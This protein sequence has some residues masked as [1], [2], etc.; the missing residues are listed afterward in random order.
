V[1]ERRLVVGLVGHLE[2]QVEAADQVPAEFLAGSFGGLREQ[3]GTD[4][5]IP[6]RSHPLGERS[7]GDLAVHGVGE[8]RVEGA[9]EAEDQPDGTWRHLPGHRQPVSVRR[10]EVVEQ[11]AERVRHHRVAGDRDRHR[12]AGRGDHLAQHREL[13]VGIEE[14]GHHLEHAGARCADAL[15]DADQFVGCGGERRGVGAGG[16]LVVAGAAGAESESPG[17]DALSGEL[18]HRRDV[19]GGGVFVVRP[20]FTHHVQA[21]GTVRDLHGDV[22]VVRDRIDRV[23]EFAERV[24]VPP[25]SLVERRTGDVLH[26]LHQLD[27]LAVIGVVDRCETDAAVAGDHGGD[28]VPRRGLQ[29]LVPRRLA[30]VVRVDVDDPRDDE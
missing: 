8:E 22:D 15:R 6:Q 3:A 13:A 23:E 25:Q 1:S 5:R 20:A 9:L 7:V 26:A 29:S 4:V 24:P 2:Q 16:G 19:V 11:A 21:Q 28:A 30:V 10:S 14:V 27:E 18:C 12:T 17:L